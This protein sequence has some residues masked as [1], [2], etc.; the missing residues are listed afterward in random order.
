MKI[1][2]GFNRR[3]RQAKPI[4][5]QPGK[6][7]TA[8]LILQSQ[9]PNSLI[10]LNFASMQ[11][12]YVISLF[13]LTAFTLGLNIQDTVACESTCC[14]TSTEVAP[15][16]ES[17]RP[18]DHESHQAAPE[19][20]SCDSGCANGCGTD[21]C[22]CTCCHGIHI[23]TAIQQEESEPVMIPVSGYLSPYIPVYSFEYTDS[24]WQPPKV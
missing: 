4:G 7:E 16:D 2:V 12:Q 5:P 21:D 15:E 23:A 19:D 14:K 17:G 8:H 18:A 3:T 6:N 10:S 24:I 13:L 22:D 1:A 9:L 11:W 20:H